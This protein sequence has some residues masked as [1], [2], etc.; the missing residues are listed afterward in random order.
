MNRHEFFIS[1][2]VYPWLFKSFHHLGDGF[3]V[4]LLAICFVSS[5]KFPFLVVE[6]SLS[7]REGLIGAYTEFEMDMQKLI[8]CFNSNDLNF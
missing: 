1:V 4:F 2:L 6:G 3:Y 5:G 7:P 8:A